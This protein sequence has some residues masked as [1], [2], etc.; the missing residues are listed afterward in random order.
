LRGP[1]EKI[2]TL[3]PPSMF[4][5]AVSRLIALLTHPTEFAA[6]DAQIICRPA[7]SLDEPRF[8]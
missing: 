5:D 2:A 1:L 3:G 4:A 7:A 8:P 6:W